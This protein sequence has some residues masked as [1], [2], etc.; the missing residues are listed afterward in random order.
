MDRRWTLWIYDCE[1]MGRS[2]KSKFRLKVMISFWNLLSGEKNPVKLK[3][4]G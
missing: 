4:V 2:P 1:K 3:L